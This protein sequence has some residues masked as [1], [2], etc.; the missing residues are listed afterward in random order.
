VDVLGWVRRAV[1]PALYA[2][3]AICLY[4]ALFLFYGR[5]DPTAA[6]EPVL[7]RQAA[8]LLL[9]YAATALLV[10]RRLDADPRWLLV[11]IFVTAGEWVNWLTQALATATGRA[12]VPD[13]TFAAP[14]AVD[15]LLLPLYIA[16]YVALRRT[17]A[18]GRASS[19]DVRV[20]LTAK[21]PAR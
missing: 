17:N 13:A 15:S 19:A 9:A 7:A 10:S 5:Q 20:A 8:N 18:G 14:L 2:H 16:G 1:K 12:V 3:I 6:A 11:P 21:E 4:A